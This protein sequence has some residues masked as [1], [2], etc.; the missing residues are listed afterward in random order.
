MISRSRAAS[1]EQHQA[2]AVISKENGSVVGMV[3]FHHR[4][5]TN[6]RLEIGFITAPQ[7]QRQG[8]TLEAVTALMTH[9]FVVLHTHRIEA[10]TDPQNTGS[11]ALLERAGFKQEGGCLRQRIILGN[12]SFGD[13]IVY[14]RLA[15][16]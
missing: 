11:R 16:D 5:P 2:F 7:Y 6:R 1:P 14:S 3:N 10:L 8:L 15:D 4:E 9:C 12:G 13:Q